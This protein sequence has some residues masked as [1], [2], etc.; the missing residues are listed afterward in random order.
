[1]ITLSLKETPAFISRNWYDN[2]CNI[3]SVINS[4][5]RLNALVYQRHIAGYHHG[6]RMNEFYILGRYFLDSCGNC[7]RIEGFIPKEHLPSIPD[8]LTRDEFRK[9]MKN[10]FGDNV[11]IR[12]P[13]TNNLPEDRL[14]CPVCKKGWDINNCHDTFVE[15]SCDD[16]SL[17]DFVGKTF[18]E[19]REHFRQQKEFLGSIQP[20]SELRNDRYIDLSLKY[21][22]PKSDWEKNVLKNERG[23]IDFKEEGLD[24]R[25]IVQ[26][27]DETCVNFWHYFHKSC[28]RKSLNQKM[29][30]SFRETF[31]KAGFK[32]FKMAPIKNRYCSCEHCAPWYRISTEFGNFKIGWRKRVI[33]IDWSQVMQKLTSEGKWPKDGLL[34]LFSKEDVTKDT[35]HIHA[36]GYEPAQ[37]YLTRIREHLTANR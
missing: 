8:V 22:N 25:Y 2:K 5:S 7:G 12:I 36:W 14:V 32:G 27:G 4:L 24:D 23:W 37:D 26:D 34:P 6:E 15:H 29:R 31:K 28:H 11:S 18:A 21:P 17:K 33:N 3:E 16:V 20:E 19:V 13:M 9:L 10:H 35:D 30:A 1:M